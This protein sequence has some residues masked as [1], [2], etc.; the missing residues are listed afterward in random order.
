MRHSDRTV[1]LKSNVVV[2]PQVL[3]DS[4][5]KIDIIGVRAVSAI[6]IQNLTH[7]MHLT[8]INGP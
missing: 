8:R 2:V 4:D 7:S 5:I 1:C 6:V 3:E